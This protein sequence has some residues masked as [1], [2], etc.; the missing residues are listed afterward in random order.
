MNRALDTTAYRAGAAAHRSKRRGGAHAIC[1]RSIRRRRR[2]AQLHREWIAVRARVLGR[3]G[4]ESLFSS[5]VAS[6]KRHFLFVPIL[7]S[8]VVLAVAV[9]LFCGTSGAVHT[10][11][12]EHD[13]VSVQ[14]DS[15]NATVREILQENGVRVGAHDR[16]TP[17]LDKNVRRNASIVIER[18]I[19]ID[20]R[21]GDGEAVTCY[22]VDGTVADLLKNNGYTLNEFDE[23][24]PETDTEI[25]ANLS[26]QI[27]RITHEEVSYTEAIAFE[28]QVQQTDSLYSGTQKVSVA[29]QEGEKIVNQ[30]IVY[31]NGVEEARVTNSEEVTREPVTQVVLQGT[32]QRAVA[33]VASAGAGVLSLNDGT[34]LSYRAVYSG[35]A[36][37]Y[38]HT[39]HNTATGTV[40]AYGTIAVDPSVIPLGTRMYI[41][42]YG[43]GVARDT[44]GAIKGTRIDLF[45]DSYAQAIRWGRRSVTIYILN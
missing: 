15:F 14:V 11:T 31:R 23:V 38:T 28:T 39:G 24:F 6:A 5:L 45:F 30:T 16:V 41:P 37:G 36:T 4:E 29:G 2:N 18:A 44:G 26:V 10:I 32:K 43:Y 34:Q 22:A 1:S 17:S 27:D 19:A 13:G 42:G 9:V 33:A 3:G 7:A 20:V 40:P 21:D 12:L 25:S 35:T 8:L